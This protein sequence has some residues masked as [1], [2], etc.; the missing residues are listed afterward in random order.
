MVKHIALSVALLF[1]ANAFAQEKKPAAGAPAKA[2]EKKPAAAAAKPGEPPKAPEA[3]A[4]AAQPPPGPPTAG[5]ETNALKP[6]VM[7]STS[8]GK[9][10]AGMMGPGSPEMPT[11]GKATCKWILN[12]LW[13]TCDIDDKAGT[14]PKASGFKGHWVIGWDFA[15]KMYVGMMVDNFGMATWWTGKIDGTK[16][17][18]ETPMEMEFMGEKMK[19]RI[20][21]DAADPKAIKFTSERQPHGK[22]WMVEG[23]AVMKPGK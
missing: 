12:N 10:N 4:P 3:A 2:E 23:E 5:P 14:G 15:Q 19:A 21:F 1:G 8:K 16:L 7:S 6:F 9:M 18:M 20:T 17:V 22:A 13:A 11:T